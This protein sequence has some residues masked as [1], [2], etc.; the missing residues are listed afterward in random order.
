MVKHIEK[1][2]KC[3][4]KKG[5]PL[6]QIEKKEDKLGNDIENSSEFDTDQDIGPFQNKHLIPTTSQDQDA[7]DGILRIYLKSTQIDF[8]HYKQTTV[9][10]RIARRMSLSNKNSYPEY[11]LFLE[12]NESEIEQL[13]DDLLLSHTEFFRD[14]SVFDALKENV[15]PNLVQHKSEKN[16]IRFWVAGCSTG[17]EI[18]SLAMCFHEYITEHNSPVTVQF[19]GTDLNP[20]HIVTARRAVYPDK[21]RKSVSEERLMR[22]FDTIPEGL[23]LTKQIREMCVFAVQDVTQDPPLPTIDLVSCRNVLIYFDSALQEIVIPLFHFALKPNG[24]LL[25]GSSETMGKFPDL[26]IP[27]NEKVNLYSKR[28]MRIKPMYR[29]PVNQ[30]SSKSR[31]GLSLIAVPIAT[32]QSTGCQDIARE[33]DNILLSTFA[34]PCLLVDSSMQI[35]QFRGNTFPY[36]TPASGEASL[37][38]SKMTSEGLMPDIYVAIEEAKKKKEKISKKNVAFKQH[39]IITF[40]DLCVIPIQDPSTGETCFLITFEKRESPVESQEWS[41]ELVGSVDDERVRLQ[42]ELQSTKEHLQ[43]IIDE[44]DE[45]NQDLWAANE[46]I[47]STNEELQSVNEE[48]EAAKEELESSNEELITLNEELRAKHIEQKESEQKFRSYIENALD[49]VFV[50]NNAGFFQ[51]ANAAMC[52]LLGYTRDELF[53]IN[54]QQVITKE[55]LEKFNLSIETIKDGGKY[56][57]E[58][59]FV[60]KDG[61]T[62]IG[63]LGASKIDENQLLGIVKDITARKQIE[64]DLRESV[65]FFRES[66]RAAFIG[67]Y[68]ADFALDYWESSEVLDQIFGIDQNYSGSIQ[69]WWDIVHPD[70][71]EMLKRYLREDVVQ[72]RIPFNKEYRIIRKSDGEVRWVNGLGK[73][74]FDDFGNLI[75]MIGTVQDITERKKTELIL[76]NTQKLDALGVLA[77]GI[78]HDFNNLLG[79][80]F[81][82][83]DLAIEGTTDCKVDAYLSK[84]INTIDRARGLTAQLLTFAKG[85]SPVRQLTSL[86]PF[87]QETVS[88]A[89]SGSNVS[90]RFDLDEDLW[91]CSIDKY[92]IGQVVN[93]IVINATQAMPNGGTILIKAQNNSLKEKEHPALVDGN[94]VTISIKDCGDGIPKEVMPRIFDPFFSTKAKG[95][96]LGLATCYSIVNRHGGCI[97]VQSEL[98]KGTVFHI[99]LPASQDACVENTAPVVSHN[100]RGTIIVMDDEMVMREIIGTMLEAMGYKTVCVSEGGEVLKLFTN[101]ESCNNDVVALIFDLTIPGG[102]GGVAAVTEIRKLN[103]R[104]PVFV[105]SGYA[106]DPVMKNPADYGFTASICKPFRKTELVEMLEMHLENLP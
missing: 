90:C 54:A 78:A 21:I 19:F 31:T 29:F 33:I 71:F 37:K 4:L 65:Y 70:D 77:G 18:Y 102:M 35:R 61:S 17:E 1:G 105:A 9:L 53:N 55:Y 46:E 97:D 48:M 100:G 44:K 58:F 91:R 63:L 28:H 40:I 74:S 22:Y 32:K 99:Y 59:N 50:I 45:V 16:P 104:I 98:G 106:D 75:S 89:L 93:N 94:Y 101:K 27:V 3:F 6:M 34:P 69:G 30:M 51:D 96:G 5:E 85:G 26:F 43:S 13:Y 79:G 62:F 23:R 84:A 68:K 42:N 52:I 11:L 66:Q 67:S 10:R 83:I 87:V 36:L 103:V 8:S 73:V 95:H 86:V 88:F 38:L 64:E 82:N 20:R 12:N 56:S 25:L 39:D 57:E 2:S 41:T 76:Q 72:K 81:G 15:F 7:L 80:I 60:R 24:Y 14:P 92:Q 49:G 47:Q